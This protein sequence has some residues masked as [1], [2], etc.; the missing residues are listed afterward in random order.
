MAWG[1]SG[2]RV[3]LG[4]QKVNSR[5]SNFELL[6]VVSIVCI[7]L[8]HSVWHS[9]VNYPTISGNKILV[10]F[11]DMLGELGV[12]CFM[13]ISGYFFLKT[14]F[15]LL[16]VIKISLEAS[17][18]VFLGVGVLKL[19]GDGVG[20]NW[21]L[22]KGFFPILN[23]AYWFLTVYVL[24]YL[25]SPLFKKLILI[26]TKRQ[27]VIFLG[28]SIFIWSVWPTIL[29]LTTNETEGYVFYNRFIWGVIMFF[30][31]A[32][33]RMYPA[34][35]FNKFKNIIIL[36]LSSTG[37]I[38]LPILIIEFFDIRRINANF[39]WRPNSFLMLI[40]S[41][42]L[43]LLFRSMEIKE[44]KLINWLASTTLGIYLLHDGPMRYFLWNKVF[45]IKD[46]S[47]SGYFIFYLLLVGWALF[48]VGF[49]VNV[50]WKFFERMILDKFFDNI[51][52]QKL[53]K[54]LEFYEKE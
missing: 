42:S 32:Y 48:L 11:I 10:D 8:Y 26:L 7:I 27:L 15:N 36:F 37:L 18:Y 16:K 23:E 38:I 39:F 5:K 14:K 6:R 25:F 50:V 12:N 47:N 31:G 33:I 17:F 29:G 9:G 21:W 46:Y 35:F 52:L 43:F 22:S 45:N 49:V 19:I 30:V 51:R 53:M 13:L 44:N 41:I 3:P 28:I 40:W 54:K 20:V 4:P 2:V 34:R 1:R 24:V